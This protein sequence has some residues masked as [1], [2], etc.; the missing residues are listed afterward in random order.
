ML[1]EE[2]VNATRRE[3]GLKKKMDE[4]AVH[5]KSMEATVKECEVTIGHLEV[6]VL[7]EQAVSGNKSALGR[8]LEKVIDNQLV[9]LQDNVKSLENSQ[10]TLEELRKNE[11]HLQT[12]LM[13]MKKD[14]E[15]TELKSMVAV[16][17]TKELIVRM[18]EE[19]LATL[20]E[21]RNMCN[22]NLSAERTLSSIQERTNLDLLK[23][24][25]EK[26]RMQEDQNT[27]LVK[28]LHFD[29]KEKDQ[30]IEEQ[31]KKIEMLSS[32]GDGLKKVIFS[33]RREG[34]LVHPTTHAVDW[35]GLQLVNSTYINETGLDDLADVNV[36]NIIDIV[37]EIPTGAL[38][39]FNST[40]CFVAG[41]K[42]EYDTTLMEHLVESRVYLV[43][44]MIAACLLLAIIAYVVTCLK[45]CLPRVEVADSG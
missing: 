42:A 24:S 11:N 15:E 38:A 36:T 9:T 7:H 25:A 1:E 32:M 31:Q 22:K 3:T 17:E 13:K 2:L 40:L 43:W 14:C 30:K 44:S 27:L 18:E 23:Q 12:S 8:K 5:L 10:L 26:I 20:E 21:E 29:I 6:R 28:K 33:L 34:V 4:D 35:N 19:H 16:E 41:A 37:N 45:M 39:S